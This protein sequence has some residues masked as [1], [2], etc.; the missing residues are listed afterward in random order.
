MEIKQ[1]INKQWV[2][3]EVKREIRKCFEIN[4]NENTT[5]QNVWNAACV[6]LTGKFIAVNAYAKKGVRVEKEEQTKP[7]ANRMKEII[8]IGAEIMTEKIEKT[9]EEINEAKS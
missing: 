4:E 2:K 6:V 3:E 1:H 5:Y 8:R 7:K 9:V